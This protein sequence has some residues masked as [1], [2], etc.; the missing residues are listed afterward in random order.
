MNELA[1]FAGPFSARARQIGKNIERYEAAWR[2]AHPG[3]D[4]GPALIRTWDRRAWS[5]ARPDKVVPTDGTVLTD[6]WIDELHRLGFRSP[7]HS[8]ALH[9]ARTGA[10]DRD[11]AVNTVLSRLGAKRSAWNAADIRGQVE[12]LISSEGMIADPSVRIEMAED[13][14]ARAALRACR[15]STTTYPSTS[16]H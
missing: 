5:E 7:T 2:M 14:T 1:G 3:E 16:E 13:L 15:C 9:A 4:P 12:L 8:T 11:A 10:L 6:R